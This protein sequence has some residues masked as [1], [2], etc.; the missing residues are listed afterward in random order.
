MATTFVLSG[1]LTRFT[2]LLKRNKPRPE[3]EPELQT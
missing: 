3:E 1:I 2:W